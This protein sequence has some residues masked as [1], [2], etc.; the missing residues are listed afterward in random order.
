MLNCQLGQ[1]NLVETEAALDSGCLRVARFAPTKLQK[2][3]RRRQPGGLPRQRGVSVTPHREHRLGDPG[4]VKGDLDRLGLSLIACARGAPLMMA[5][6]ASDIFP[7]SVAIADISE[8]SLAGVLFKKWAMSWDWASFCRVWASCT[9][10]CILMIWL[11]LS[12]PP[13]LVRWKKL[14]VSF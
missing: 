3:Q 6:R 12:L 4:F 13:T 1:L 10:V 14:L 2:L 7:A 8:S 9:I 11:V 5:S